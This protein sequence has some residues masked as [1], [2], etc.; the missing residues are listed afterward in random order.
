MRKFLAVLIAI[1]M[2]A[3][4]AGAEGNE[5]TIQAMTD[6]ADIQ[7][8]LDQGITIEK[9]YYTDG[10]GFSTSEFTTKDPEE[11]EGL[12]KAVNAIVVGEKVN[13]SITDW[14]PQIVF[15]LSDGTSGGVRF[16]GNWLSIGGKDNY[17]ISNAE[18]FRR[19]TSSLVEKYSAEEGG[20]AFG[21]GSGK[22]LGGW[23]ITE[24]VEGK[25]TPEAKAAFDKAMNGLVGASYVPVALLGT[26]VVAGINYCILCQI[27]PVV[28][29]AVPSW[30]L[31]YIYADLE[32][33]AKIMNVYDIYIDRHAQP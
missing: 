24:A 8:K 21:N 6:L 32:G 19:L 27:T 25:L 30:A 11:I 14:Y 28:P 26:Q 16:E 33:N 17:E 12:W 7:A 13:E 15:Y 4:V 10:Y 3:S 20:A 31:V 22:L 9:A 23:E 5:K 1:L 29:D 2:M 18:E